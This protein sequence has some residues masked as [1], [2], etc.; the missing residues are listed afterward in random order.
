MKKNLSIKSFFA[1][2]AVLLLSLWSAKHKL[3][4]S[5][6]Q[7]QICPPF[8]FDCVREYVSSVKSPVPECGQELFHFNKYQLHFLLRFMLRIASKMYARLDLFETVLG[9]YEETPMNF[10][11][12]YS[13][14][15]FKIC[16]KCDDYAMMREEGLNNGFN[17]YCGSS[18]YGHNETMTGTLFLPVEDSFPGM[19]LKLKPGDLSGSIFMHGFVSPRGPSQIAPKTVLGWVYYMAE[20][21]TMFLLKGLPGIH[22]LDGKTLFNTIAPVMVAT[23]GAVV[24][25]P[26]YIGYGNDKTLQKP[27]GVPH[28]YQ[29]STIPLWLR[30]EE[31]VKNLTKRED[32]PLNGNVY[33]FGVSEGGT[34]VVPV[35]NAMHDLGAKVVAYPGCVPNNDYV[36]IIM[37]IVCEFYPSK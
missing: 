21:G 37:R 9:D 27:T 5:D 23:K 34:G 18:S 31:F 1:S 19:P 33:V 15:A 25:E 29:T 2:I 13:V 17:K 8:D 10:L 4:N 6:E 11:P 16:A 3:I 32:S 35:G 7:N 30:A 26:D 22:P 14:R 24:L 28:G 12:S 36:S 20:L